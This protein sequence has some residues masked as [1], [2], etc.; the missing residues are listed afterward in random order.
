MWVLW[1]L[2]A[3]DLSA[4]TAPAPHYNPAAAGLFSALIVGGGQAYNGQWEKGAAF[5]SMAVLGGVGFANVRARE[6][7]DCERET[8]GTCYYTASNLLGVGLVAW[9]VYGI[10]DAAWT[11]R[12]LNVEALEVAP[13]VGPS[14]NLGLRLS[15]RP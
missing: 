5:L 6:M 8:T 2:F 15:W 3:A 9:W 1:V 12:R 11:A 13:T 4:Q 14:G 7:D 10:V